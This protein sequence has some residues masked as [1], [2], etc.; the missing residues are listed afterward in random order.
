MRCRVYFVSQQEKEFPVLFLHLFS[1]SD[2][3]S[4]ITGGEADSLFFFSRLFFSLA[5]FGKDEEKGRESFNFPPTGRSRRKRTIKP[6]SI[7]K[8]QRSFLKMIFE[9]KLDF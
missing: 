3:L 9:G 1:Y 5:D 7:S 2:G 8:T 4:F 6:T